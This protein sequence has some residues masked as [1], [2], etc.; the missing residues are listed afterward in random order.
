MLQFQRQR[1]L[2]DDDMG[3]PGNTPQCSPGHTLLMRLL[4]S[5]AALAGAAGGAGRPPSSGTPTQPRTSQGGSAPAGPDGRGDPVARRLHARSRRERPGGR[6]HLGVSVAQ[7]KP[8]KMMTLSSLQMLLMTLLSVV[9]GCVYWYTQ[10]T[11]LYAYMH[12]YETSIHSYRHTYM[13]YVHTCTRAYA[14]TYSHTYTHT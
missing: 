14:Q 3:Y 4:P 6:R 8:K 11:Y 2:E 10:C 12:I 7:R 5:E 9:I 1:F 13:H